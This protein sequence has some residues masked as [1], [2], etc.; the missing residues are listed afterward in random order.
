MATYPVVNRETGEQKEVQMSIHAWSQ[1][2]EDNPGWQRDWS[3]PTTAPGCGEV[4][5]FKINSR[6]LTQDGMMS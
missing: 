2:L 6:K 3:D 1:W 5:E 4:G